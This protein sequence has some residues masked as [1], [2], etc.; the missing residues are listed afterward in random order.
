[1]YD[2][3]IVGAGPAGLSAA[4]YAGRKGLNTLVI[5][6][7]IGGQGNL[8]S[9]IENYPGALPQ[10]GLELMDKFRVQAE[11]F[12]AAFEFSRLNSIEKKDDYFI[13]NLNNDKKIE[14]MS[15]IIAN[16]AVPRK[17]GAKGEDEFYGKGV[18]TCTTCDGPLYKDKVACVVGGGNSA[19]EGALDLSVHAK[20]VYLIHRRQDF[21]ADKITI[22]KVLKNDKIELILESNIKEIKGDKFVTSII[23]E[24]VT[25]K[26]KKEVA[27]D[28]VFLEIGYHVETGFVND[29]VEL[30][31][32]N[33]IIVDKVCKTSQ[34]GIF[35]AGD[36]TNMPHK[37]A[38][39]A[40]GEGAKAALEAYFYVNSEKE[41][42]N[43]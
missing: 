13:L 22:D 20:K 25:T 31:N 19:L 17:L 23:V 16:G 28:G 12:G 27:L 10:S 34:R 2:T 9:H 43:I 7:N 40:S 38:I 30:N 39:I 33:E 24:N 29:L 18:S 36:V 26:E 11:K 3:I 32:K 41:R 8:T 5:T 14:T 1:M 4:I 6:E 21:N 37:Q 35:A 42:K 15:V